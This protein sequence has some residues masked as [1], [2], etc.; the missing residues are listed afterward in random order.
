M[1]MTMSS[2][3]PLYQTRRKVLRC[4]YCALLPNKKLRQMP[5]AIYSLSP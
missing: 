5:K 2:W 4:D 3:L 1:Q